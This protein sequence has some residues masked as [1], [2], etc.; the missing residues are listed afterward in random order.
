VAHLKVIIMTIVLKLIEED[1]KLAEDLRKQ[2][3]FVWKNTFVRLHRGNGPI[4]IPDILKNEKYIAMIRLK[5]YSS[6]WFSQVVCGSNGE[7]LKPVCSHPKNNAL[8]F[9]SKT[10][11]ITVMCYKR[12]EGFEINHH[13]K[14]DNNVLIRKDDK[15]WIETRPIYPLPK[16][17][18]DI[19]GLPYGLKHFNVHVISAIKKAGSHNHN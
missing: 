9:K 8:Y 12:M 5:E 10:S 4:K 7:R 18:D 19:L 2:G 1:P 14:I 15:L 13:V 3:L 17:H 16:I 6:D 11:L